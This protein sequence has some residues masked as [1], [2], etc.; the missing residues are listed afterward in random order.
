MTSTNKPLNIHW[1][2]DYEPKNR[3]V[4]VHNHIII[5]APRSVVWQW[6][7]R[8]ENWPEWYSN[9]KDVKITKSSKPHQ[10]TDKSKF[11]WKTFGIHL[12]T[13][14]DQYN[15]EKL[16]AWEA[17]GFLVH[18]YHAWG[19]EDTGNNQCLVIT[20]ERQYGLGA[21]LFH[22]VFPRRMW[23]KHHLWLTQ[24]KKMA[25]SSSSPSI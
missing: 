25:E 22:W 9:A 19:M 11:E 5:N 10:L 23:Q 20:E 17:V 1:P 8:A 16:I 24:L 6:L 4:H 3:R 12:N 2:T 18:A 7:M 14:V 15:H 21:W 13:V